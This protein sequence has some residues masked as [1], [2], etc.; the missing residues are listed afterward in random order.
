MSLIHYVKP[1]LEL[2]TCKEYCMARKTTGIT[3]PNRRKK[4]ETSVPPAAALV[5]P[6]VQ[7]AA[8]EKIH[9]VGPTEIRQSG[10]KH[11]TPSSHVPVNLIS[12]NVEEEIRRRAYEL[13]LQRRAAT[14]GENGDQSQD[15]LLAESEV[16]S[17]QGDQKQRGIAAGGARA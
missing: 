11:G 3:T 17:R 7:E 4:A 14:G 12:A 16:R 15:W 1:F 8:Q 6:E 9:Q 13:Y 2:G 10:P 5:A